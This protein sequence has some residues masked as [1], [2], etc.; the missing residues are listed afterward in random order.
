MGV[1]SDYRLG[2][3]ET[4]EFDRI[5]LEEE[6]NIV[7]IFTSISTSRPRSMFTIGGGG[8][9]KVGSQRDDCQ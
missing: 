5:L 3:V 1:R 7:Q 4:G 8:S 9:G 2:R 6:G